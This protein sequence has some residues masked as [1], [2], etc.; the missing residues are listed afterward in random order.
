M[1]NTIPQPPTPSRVRIAVDAM[2]GDRAPR[3]EVEAALQAAASSDVQITLVGRTPEIMSHVPGGRLPASVTILHADDVVSMADEPSTIVKAR[4]ESSLYKAM[5]LMRT[6]EIDAVVSAGNTGA[7]MATATM[8]CGRLRGVSRPTIGSF[9]PTQRDRPTLVVDVGANVDS[10]PR[11]L[12][13]YAVMGSVYYAH[14]VGTPQPTVGL[15]SVGEEREKGNAVTK[16][17]YSLLENAPISFVGNV[18]GRDILKG[19]VDVVVCDGFEGNIVLKFAESVIGFLKHRFV[20]YARTGILPAVAMALMRPVLRKVLSGMDYQE[21]G[22]VPLLGVNGVV[23][24]G[25]GSSSS[26]ALLNMIR[27]AEEVVRADVNTHIQAALQSGIQT[28]VPPETTA[29]NT[30]A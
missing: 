6:G 14:I 23:I 7:V 2:G 16:E 26:K 20:S 22:G 15:L 17:T 18:E 27:R 9:F 19:S 25:H 13:D 28:A 8:M 12:H 10:K 21:Y 1:E 4:K 30:T 29:E 24:I 5:N 11:F 3:H